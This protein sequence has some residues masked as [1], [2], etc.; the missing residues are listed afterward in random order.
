ARGGAAGPVGRARAISGDA[1]CCRRS[2]G[3][4]GGH[5]HAPSGAGVGPA[6]IG[7]L[8]PNAIDH[9][10]QRQPGA[11]VHAQVPPRVIV[12]ARAP[13]DDVLAE[14]TG[15]HRTTAGEVLD[16][17]HRVPVL[18]ADRVSDHRRRVY[19]G[20][21]Y[22]TGAS[23]AVTMSM[24]RAEALKSCVSMFLVTATAIPV[25]VLPQAKL[26]PAPPTPKVVAFCG[27]EGDP[28]P[29]IA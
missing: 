28:R 7:A 19:G 23:A 20:S 25:A 4:V 2:L 24:S 21:G 26:P 17:R 18:D 3:G 27:S 6:V 11:A 29:P 10:S 14:Q 15:G 13:E 22:L 1:C 5:D 8:E 9:A 12:I 16:P